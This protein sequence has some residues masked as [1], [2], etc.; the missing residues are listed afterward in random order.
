[1]ISLSFF[2]LLSK[3]LSCLFSSISSFLNFVESDNISLILFLFSFLLIITTELP[4]SAFWITKFLF[5]VGLS[6]AFNSASVKLLTGY[7]LLKKLYDVNSVSKSLDFIELLC[8]VV[9]SLVLM[10]RNGNSKG[11]I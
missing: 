1:M 7:F 6:E 4:L 11:R 10:S 3:R 8:D 9:K 2:S 5:L